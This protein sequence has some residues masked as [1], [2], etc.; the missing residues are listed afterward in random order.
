MW[1][2]V[3]NQTHGETAHGQPDS[4]V[5]RSLEPKRCGSGSSEL[6]QQSATRKKQRRT[7]LESSVL[8]R[9]KS[10]IQADPEIPLN[11]TELMN[12]DH[13]AHDLKELKVIDDYLR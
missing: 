1:A 7:A 6:I 2:R 13:A 5:G 12:V 3:C 9:S 11:S 8:T 4:Q 10:A